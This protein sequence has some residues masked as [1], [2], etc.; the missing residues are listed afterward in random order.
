[1]QKEDRIR[2]YAQSPFEQGR[3]Y[4]RRGM[5][6][7]RN[8]IVTFPHATLV[9]RFD[10]V[11]YLIHILERVNPPRTQEEVKASEAEAAAYHARQTSR[12]HTEVDYGGYI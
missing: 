5:E 6:Q 3:V 10:V 7:L 12:S 2:L 9:D 4:I 11:A 1:M 8:Q